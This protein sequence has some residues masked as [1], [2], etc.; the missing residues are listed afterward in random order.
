[1]ARKKKKNWPT[2]ALTVLIVAFVAAIL[3]V[4]I[5]RQEPAPSPKVSRKPAPTRPATPEALPKAEPAKKPDKAPAVVA[6]IEKRPLPAPTRRVAIIIDDIGYDLQAVR[7]LLAIDADITF[8]IL[9]HLAN[10][11]KAAEMLQRA[12]RE[13][14][15][16]LPME[17]LT[18]PKDK[19]GAGALFTDM[20]EAE[21]LH[22]MEENF[23]G[24]PYVS[25]VNNHMGSKFMSD[26]EKLAVVFREL[27]KRGL[28]FIDS[29]TT[30]DTKTAAAA[31][32][33][34]LPVGSRTV[35]LDNERDY[36]KIY[37]ILLE[38]AG[39]GASSTPVIVIGH[40]YPE[41]IRALRDA[42]TIFREKG[43]EVVPVSRLIKNQRG[44]GSS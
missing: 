35:F 7:D 31:K 6:K 36:D 16:H 3:Y 42:Q 37:R 40:P 28:F 41:T 22:Q 43:V 30:G 21:L 27:K 34:P 38:A 9:P 19:P 32:R 4:L 12:G 2:T 18:Y 44:A 13:T 20:N 1:M 14:I 26:E 17:P 11:R 39:S 29:R 23:A 5:F 25:G 15:L 24:V 33:H 8:A 10:T